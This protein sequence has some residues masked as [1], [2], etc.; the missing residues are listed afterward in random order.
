MKDS[1]HTNTE[2]VKKA[3]EQLRDKS[4]KETENIEIFN[5]ATKMYKTANGQKTPEDILLRLVLF[6]YHVCPESWCVE[7]LTGS[8][9]PLTS[10]SCEII[11]EHKQAL[12]RG[13]S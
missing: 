3:K 10:L 7:A 4:Y 1:K 2:A 8:S 9:V 11:R 13:R 6:C 12:K 5:L